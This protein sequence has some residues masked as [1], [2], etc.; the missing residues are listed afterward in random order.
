VDDVELIIVSLLIAVVV[1]SAAARAINV[2]Y[3]I[4][5]VL[6]GTALGFVPGLPEVRMD[7]D[8]V[9]LIFLPPLL[10]SS[11]F[12]ANLNDLRA[13]LRPITLLSVGLVL[14]TMVLVAVTAHALIDGMSWEVA[15]T[16]GAILGPTDPIAA[17]TIARRLGVPRR[18]VSVIEG[19]SLI[20][21]ATALV[22]Y[23]IARAAV[24]GASFSLLDASWDFLWKAAGGAGLGLSVGWLIA[25]V[26]RRL[27][28]PLIENTMALMTS[29]AAYVPA[30]K[31]HLSAVVAAVTAGIYVGWQAP[32]IASPASRIRGFGM[33]E[34]LQ[35]LLNAILFVLIGLQL[36]GVL[37][38]LDR[39]QAWTLAGY[40]LAVSLAVILARLI[41]Q[42][43]T[44]YIVRLLDRR[45]SQRARRT[46]WRYR[47]VGG[48]AGMRGAVSLA[49]A[50]ALPGN[51]PHRDLVVFLTFA[52]IFATLVLQGLTLAPL[53]RRLGVIDDGSD[54]RDEELTARLVATQAALS[55]IEELKGEDWTRPDT[56]ERLEGAYNYRRRRLKARAGKTDDDGT[57]EHRSFA[58]QTV[59]REILEAQRA[60]IVRLRNEGTISNDVMHRIERE[61]DLEDERL[62]I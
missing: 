11:A 17:T 3:P 54:E 10:Y 52:V 59:L 56:L 53:I 4:V 35:F 62:E 40:A 49:A 8:L 18:L 41:W 21:D 28:D 19:E 6:G 48:W 39:T 15:F 13:N 42:N 25:E 23:N 9:L 29:Y 43:T 2:P 47:L 20:N 14:F 36:P 55:R 31:L 27:E 33:W 22:A 57:Y 24:F 16:L 44:V 60:E 1:L 46:T 51:F 50:L 34:Q 37:D 61:L 58:Y 45:E 26:R 38:G 30:E 7:P 12:F 32:R 5:L